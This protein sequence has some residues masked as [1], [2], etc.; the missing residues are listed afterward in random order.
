MQKIFFAQHCISLIILRFAFSQSLREEENREL[1]HSYNI[2]A[3]RQQK[4]DGLEQ[5]NRELREEV[6]TL[7]DTLERLNSVVEAMTAAQNQ[8]LQE[9]VQRT[10]ILEIVS[11]PILGVPTS[12]P[13]Y[14][15]PS[16]FPWG[17]PPNFMPEGYRPQGV[18]APRTTVMPEGYRPQD[19]EVSRAATIMTMPQ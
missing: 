4:I 14:P 3:S 15:M 7:R 2:R 8:P 1:S 5:E 16:G 18:E 19:V 17:M 13:Q 10:V 6:S 11:A 12:V 9:E